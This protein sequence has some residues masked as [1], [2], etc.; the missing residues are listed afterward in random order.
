MNDETGDV[1]SAENWACYQTNS[2]AGNLAALSTNLVLFNK[3]WGPLKKLDPSMP[4][5]IHT[6]SQQ[7]V[8]KDHALNS[9]GGSGYRSFY[10]YLPHD[11]FWN[12]KRRNRNSDMVPKQTLIHM[13][14]T[15]DKL[16]LHQDKKSCCL[17]GLSLEARPVVVI[18]LTMH[19]NGS[20]GF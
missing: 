20:R 4:T 16:W 11:I 13:A 1:V 17:L 14:Y 6:T 18:C 9:K 12:A 15:E 19:C 5:F 3:H 7:T 8:H 10:V 2:W